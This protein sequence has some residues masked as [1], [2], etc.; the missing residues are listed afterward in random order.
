[1]RISNYKKLAAT[2][3]VATLP[4]GV[5]AGEAQKSPNILLIVAD[6][7]G[8]SDIG[9]FG[10]EIHTPTLDELAESGFKLTNFHTAPACSPTRASLLTGVDPHIAGLGN[11]AEELAPNQEGQPGYE[12]HINDRV[13]TLTELLKDAG[14]R[15]YITGKWHLGKDEASNPQARGFDHSFV[16]LP[17]GASH[18]SDMKPAYA[19]TP[20][21]KAGYTDNGVLLD[22]LPDTFEYSSQYYAERLISDLKEGQGSEQPF[23]AMLSFTAPHW[24]LQAPDTVIEKY[25]G[26]YD[27][28]Y[29]VLFEHRL[30]AQQDLG[31]IPKDAE[32]SE[33]LAKGQAWASLTPEQRKTEVR[34]M[35]IYAAMVDEMDRYTGK[36]VNYLKETGQ[37]ENTLIVFLSDNG[38]EG[39]DIDETWPADLFPKIRAV[40]DQTNDF[41]YEQMGRPG[42]YTFLGP[43]WGWAASP[44]FS[45]QKGF[46]TEGGTRSIGIIKLPNTDSAGQRIDSYTNVMDLAPTVL[47]IA[48]LEAPQG[49]Y[50][51][52]NVAPIQGVS[53]MPILQGEANHTNERIVGGELFG[54]Y[55]VRK[56]DWKMVLMPA[57]HG[58]G[59]AQLFNL[60]TDLAERHDVAAEHPNVMAE[61]RDHWQAYVQQNHVILPNWVSG[62]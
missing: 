30:Q 39:H 34:A 41:S 57:P 2:I 26:V 32:G 46:P 42:S 51:G 49:L 16:L 14:Y 22:K 50:K 23:F 59:V 35:E 33:R 21:A 61:M 38:P 55:F 53:L 12:G 40:I 25:K 48:N 20:E 3:V 13:V 19:P 11:M 62:Y 60:K 24:P 28:G 8:H 31:I 10:S 36:V 5:Y 15:T 17:G 54:K 18:F 37:Y 6:D 29:D 44:A 56:G 43:N 58:T 7:L 27:A 45:M 52:K 4:A 1:M 47:E 9:S